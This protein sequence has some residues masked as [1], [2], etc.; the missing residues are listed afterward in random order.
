LR[1]ANGTA[2]SE[3]AITLI[4]VERAI[5]KDTEMHPLVTITSIC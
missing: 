2:K 3:A 4:T 1:P 5:N